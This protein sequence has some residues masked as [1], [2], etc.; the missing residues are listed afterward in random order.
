MSSSSSANPKKLCLWSPNCQDEFMLASNEEVSLY[1]VL[2]GSKKRRRP[3]N[4]SVGEVIVNQSPYHNDEVEYEPSFQLVGNSMEPSFSC[5]AWCESADDTR[6]I[7]IGHTNGVVTFPRLG[8]N[9]TGQS[10]QPQ[11]HSSS[12]G[13]GAGGLTRYGSGAPTSAVQYGVGGSIR[14]TSGASSVASSIVQGGLGSASFGLGFDGG[15]GVGRQLPPSLKPRVNRSCTVVCWDPENSAR[16]AVGYEKQRSE[17]SLLVYD[18]SQLHQDGSAR[19]ARNQKTV[20][21]AQGESI[22]SMAWARGQQGCIIA[23]VGNKAIRMYDSRNTKDDMRSVLTKAVYG[24]CVDPHSTNRFASFLPSE[25]TVYVWDMRRFAE[26]FSIINAWT[27]SGSEKSSNAPKISQIQWCKPNNNAI[28][29][30]LRSETSILDLWDI[31]E[32]P[33]MAVKLKGDGM[34]Q[35]GVSHKQSR[36]ESLKST[37]SFSWHPFYRNTMLTM[38]YNG[39]FGVRDVFDILPISW[40]VHGEICVAV[41]KKMY[42]LTPFKERKPDKLSSEADSLHNL[43]ISEVMRRRAQMGYRMNAAENRQIVKNDGMLQ[44]AWETV[45]HMS[46]VFQKDTLTEMFPAVKDF[47]GIY[48]V[49]MEPGGENAERKGVGVRYHEIPKRKLCLILCN[50]YFEIDGVNSFPAY[51]K[52][53][54]EKNEY[55]KAVALAVFHGETRR[56]IKI[57]TNAGIADPKR[58]DHFN[59]VAMALGGYSEG[60]TSLYLQE[61]G[62]TIIDKLQHPYM[63]AA[64]AFLNKGRERNSEVLKNVLHTPG[65]EIG[66]KLG[67]ALRFLNEPNLKDYI[68]LL[69]RSMMLDGNLEGLLLTGLRSIGVGLLEEYVNRTSDV[70]TASL[71]M[72]YSYTSDFRDPRVNAWV[73]AYRSLL[74]SWKM[75]TERALFDVDRK[76]KRQSKTVK[77]KGQQPD[78]AQQIF[79]RCN[80]CSSSICHN[81]IAPGPGKSRVFDT[82]SAPGSGPPAR[83]RVTSCPN[84]RKPLPRCAVC[85]FNLGS[86][87]N[88]PGAKAAYLQKNA[89]GEKG[90]GEKDNMGL[91]TSHFDDWFTWCQVCRHGGHASHLLEWFEKHDTCPVSQCT[92]KCANSVSRVGDVEGQFYGNSEM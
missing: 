21:M 17:H 75:W 22:D 66:D 42:A 57:L 26:P 47:D 67:F 24:I 52:K 76:S 68:E 77:P 61:I 71:I 38:D 14:R 59:L 49:I 32:G 9:V 1:Q 30:V 60:N 43:D 54:E 41:E 79:V 45:A 87:T 69:K 34:Q 88:G 10:K 70:Q 55:E 5:A 4:P 51:V 63:K 65:L 82:Y 50:W 12:G 72:S 39:Q 81:M 23:G 85:L 6:R 83:P 64:F 44:K 31:G 35:G 36:S 7:A 18:L 89:S 92:C 91:K 3:V 86:S 73:E 11:L 16:L 40:S 20:D 62:G 58:A 27:G 2:P 37:A 53:L 84:C 8:N 19:A 48:S 15:L 29:S 78:N 13:N 46:A 25:G 28:L 90:A 80:F 74:D 56:A 33:E